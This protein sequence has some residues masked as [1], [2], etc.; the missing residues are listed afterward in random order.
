MCHNFMLNICKYAVLFS[1]T[2]KVKVVLSVLADYY[3]S[4][5][6]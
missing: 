6:H 1:A 5:H 2:I 4:F 3:T